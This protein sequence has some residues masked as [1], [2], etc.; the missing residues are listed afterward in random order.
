[1]LHNS[2]SHELL[3]VVASVH[4]QGAGKTLND[5]ASSLTETADLETSS[6]VRKV[7]GGL[8]L[9]WNVVDER[10]VGDIHALEGPLSE[11]SNL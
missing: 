9:D 5:W 10:D 2:D 4:H 7:L 6:G 11:E 3:S 8:F 1:M